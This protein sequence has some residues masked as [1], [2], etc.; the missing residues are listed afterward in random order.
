MITVVHLSFCFMCTK[1][2]IGVA[3]HRKVGGGGH[4]LFPENQK[5]TPKQTKGH[6]DVKAQD[7]ILRLSEINIPEHR[8]RA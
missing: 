2:T 6:N 4:K 8:K 1:S 3:R 5:T 7:R